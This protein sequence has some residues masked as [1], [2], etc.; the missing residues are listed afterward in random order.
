[1]AGVATDSA[2][3]G[4]L[5]E[6]PAT[7]VRRRIV[8]TLVEARVFELLSAGLDGD[9]CKDGVSSRVGFTFHV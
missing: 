5:H 6:A 7:T 2:I 3:T 4:T 9:V 8:E 1:M